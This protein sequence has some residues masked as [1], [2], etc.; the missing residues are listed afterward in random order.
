VYVQ[1]KKSKA[2]LQSITK[3]QGVKSAHVVWGRPDLVAF[4]EAD[5]QRA[6]GAVVL[7]KIQAI[8]GI[9]MTDTR[10]VIEV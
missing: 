3:V 10:I 6:L 9:E 8:A 1:P 5:D 4:V 2:V 7:K